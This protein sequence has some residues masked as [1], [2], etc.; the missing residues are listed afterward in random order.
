VS[1]VVLS[2][3][4][5]AWSQTEAAPPPAPPPGETAPATTAPADAPL[6]TPAEIPPAPP[7]PS[8]SVDVPTDQVVESGAVDVANLDLLGLDA[9]LGIRL[10]TPSASTATIWDA[11]AT[12]VVITA[13]DIRTRGYTDLPEV[14]QDLPGFDVTIPNGTVYMAAYQRGYRTPWTQRTLLMINGIV[15]NHLWRQN[16]D[17]TR[18]YSLA[19][20]DR[21]EVVYGPASAVYGP[22]AFLGVINVITKNGKSL[23]SGTVRGLANFHGGSFNTRSADISLEGKYDQVAFAVSGRL[24]RSDEPDLSVDSQGRDRWGWMKKDQL[25]NTDIWGP[26]LAKDAEGN[27]VWNNEGVPLGKYADPTDDYSLQSTVSWKGLTAGLIYWEQKEGYGGYYTFD[28]SQ[29]NAYWATHSHQAYVSYDWEATEKL[30]LSM[31]ALARSSRLYGDFI[32]AEPD[33]RAARP[34]FNPMQSFVSFTSWNSISNAVRTTLNFD[35]DFLENLKFAGGFKYERKELTKAF[36]IPGYWDAYGSSDYTGTNG[37]GTGLGNVHSSAATYERPP[38]PAAEMPRDNL[39]LMEDIGGF[40]QATFDYKSFRVNGGVRYDV[41]SLYGDSFNP[42]VTAS[43]GFEKLGPVEKGALKLMY[44][45]AFQEPAPVQLFGGWTGR[46]DNPALRP[47]RGGNLEGGVLL[48]TG[49][50]FTDISAYRADYSNVFIESVTQGKTINLAQRHVYGLEYRGR[51]MISN[52]ISSE[53]ADFTAFWNYSYT[54]AMSSYTFDFSAGDWVPRYSEIG[55]ISPHKI[56]AGFSLPVSFLDFTLKGNWASNRTL[57]L[58][59]PLR[60]PARADGGREL[61]GYVV[62]DA[63]VGARYK[64]ARLAVKCK[65]LFDRM[66]YHPGPEAADS[67]DTFTN[68]RS[69]GYHNSLV[70]QPGRSVMVTLS[71]DL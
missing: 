43:Y 53:W 4:T 35:Y 32:E 54:R 70:P 68:P 59:N 47:E 49:G 41:N 48:Q 71:L 12:V 34:D 65:N 14:M 19:N 21:I 57:Y 5:S 64:S 63:I 50:V 31:L 40:L 9:L 29:P 17:I 1:S 66:Y 18:Q 3:S 6:A 33:W 27:A 23:D 11:P 15:D 56:N 58:T 39:F 13:E 69:S 52:F 38:A 42:R 20:V 36:D 22:N 51:A 55:D 61:A 25:A 16:A 37:F 7:A 46:R 26:L 44:G 30:K 2:L 8:T 10:V 60:D 62:F 67:G 28:R 24:F 45:R